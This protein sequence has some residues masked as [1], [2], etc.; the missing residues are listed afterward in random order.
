MSGRRLGPTAVAVILLGLTGLAA[1]VLV[2]HR[3]GAV[4]RPRYV[5]VN[6]T[7]EHVHD[8]AFKMSLKLAEKRS[9]IE[10]ALVFLKRLPPGRTIEQVAVDLFGR[11]Q[12]GRDRGG[13][14]ILYLYSEQENL[15]KIEISYGLE[16]L[17]P[18]AFCRQMEEAAKTYMLSEIPQDFVSELL[19][20][21][22]LRATEGPAAADGS[23]RPPAWLE[24]ARFSG[25]GGAKAAGYHR[26]LEDY[27]AAVR[28]LPRSD[29]AE[30]EPATDPEDTMRRYLRS[31]ERGLGEPQLPLLTEGSQVFRVIVPRSEAQQLRV[32]RFYARAMPYQLLRLDAWGLAVFR[33]GTPN[34]PVVL[35]RAAGGRWL[36]DEPKAWTYFHR[37]EDG[38]DF[39]PK[40]GDLP[41]LPALRRIGQPNA[42]NPIYQN[43]VRTAV[44]RPYPFSL[45]GAVAEQER[46]SRERPGDDRPY[47][48]AGELY[49]FEVNWIS[50]S[51]E[52]FE[53]AAAIAPDRLDYQWRLYDLYLN[54]S[55]A[56][57]ALAT[58]KSLAERLPNDRQVQDWYRFY[59]RL[60]DFKPGEFARGLTVAA[61]TGDEVSISRR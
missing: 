26:R 46:A 60:Y 47:A 2:H 39:F 42:Q 41:F 55:Q 12:I 4:E 52:M 34:L 18:D 16:A 25:G 8:L 6:E 10:N 51:L 24:T 59:R 15:F 17:F 28:L 45:A 35:R 57:R 61:Q 31:L 48:A 20:T 32:F 36:V 54:N 21:M 5:F 38:V 30:F 23:W 44:P 56:D 27:Q 43:R 9:G 37:Y 1:W 49:L 53:R 29:L 50:R 22:N 13:R 3:A 19:I 7:D 33:P 40:Y 11:W 14:G 58:L